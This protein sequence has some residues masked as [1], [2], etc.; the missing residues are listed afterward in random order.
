MKHRDTTPQ[1]A[2]GRQHAGA[3]LS[4]QDQ[5]LFRQAMDA[6]TALP[7]NNKRKQ[8]WRARP[9]VQPLQTRADEQAVIEELLDA[10]PVD[11]E[12]GDNLSWRRNGLQ[13]AVLRKLRRG[14]YSCQ[15]ELDLHGLTTHTA[16]NAL[17]A[18]LHDAK[19]HNW[20][21]VRIVHGKGLRSGHRGP[22]L[23]AKVGGWLR[24]RDEVLAFCSTPD[25]DG[26]TGAIYVLLKHT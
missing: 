25:H 18:F 21:C 1:V 13:L 26:G 3:Q 2:S 8:P 11:I 10:P 24:C 6:V 23:K 12:T 14:H 9:S 22:V 17:A 5:T 16:R 19:L 7:D 4:Q 15:S 20:R